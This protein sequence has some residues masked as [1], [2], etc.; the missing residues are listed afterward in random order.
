MIKRNKTKVLKNAEQKSET[1]LRLCV[2]RCKFILTFEK[3]RSSTLN[4]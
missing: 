3:S 2:S 1:N 4:L